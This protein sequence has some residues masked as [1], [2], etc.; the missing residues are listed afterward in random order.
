MTPTPTLSERF[1]SDEIRR[2]ELSALLQHP[3]LVLAFEALK[4][5]IEPKV[6]DLTT[7]NPVVAAARYQQT[8]GT[9][10]ILQGLHRLTREFAPPKK[11]L[12]RPPIRE[13]LQ[14]DNT[15]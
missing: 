8:A 10:H 11:V 13:T 6:T 2:Q 4:D 5:E 14:D 7:T 15:P 1:Q 12:G 9:N 3:T